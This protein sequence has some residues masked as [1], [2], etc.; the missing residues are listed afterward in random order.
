MVMNCAALYTA[1]SM[2]VYITLSGNV[3]KAFLL[4]ACVDTAPRILGSDQHGHSGTHKSQ[5][6]RF[7]IITV[8]PLTFAGGGIQG[9]EAPAVPNL[10]PSGVLLYGTHFIRVISVF[11]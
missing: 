11:K 5:S 1:D 2:T 4:Q 7:I 8:C 3:C 9:W 10:H 6:R